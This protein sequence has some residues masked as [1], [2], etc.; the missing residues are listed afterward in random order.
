V[1]L[2]TI[3]LTFM[4]RMNLLWAIVSGVGVMLLVTLNG[5]KLLSSRMFDAIEGK[6]TK[7]PASK[8]KN[9]QRYDISPTVDNEFEII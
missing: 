1:G 2:I 7:K 4:G 6:G 8:R 3:V 5:M 9:G